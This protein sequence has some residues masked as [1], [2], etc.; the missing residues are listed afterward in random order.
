MCGA[1]YCTAAPRPKA[2][3]STCRP[4]ATTMTC[5]PWH[6]APLSLHSPM[7]LTRASMMSS[8]RRPSLASGIQHSDALGGICYETLR[9]VVQAA[10][11]KRLL[12]VHIHG[13]ACRRSTVHPHTSYCCWLWTDKSC[14]YCRRKNA[15]FK[16]GVVLSGVQLLSWS[17]EWSVNTLC[18]SAVKVCGRLCLAGNV[19]WLQL[20]MAS[21]TC[22]TIWSSPSASSPLWAARWVHSLN[23]F[24]SQPKTLPYLW[25][26]VSAHV[27]L[28][29]PITCFGD[30]LIKEHSSWLCPLSLVSLTFWFTQSSFGGFWRKT[31][32]SDTHPTLKH[33]YKM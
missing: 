11:W 19:R 15:R 3:F 24:C 12:N 17:K 31:D 30:Q 33:V 14:D 27:T 2:S 32:T 16:T 4:A 25:H 6:G 7:S 18:L 8:S 1:S 5:S 13:L 23:R 22:L 28:L 21:M 26:T 10:G 20:T 29:S 9:V